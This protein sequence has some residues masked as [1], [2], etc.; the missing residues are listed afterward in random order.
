M[1]LGGQES[2]ERRQEIESRRIWPSVAK[3]YLRAEI[4][5]MWL[6]AGEARGIRGCELPLIGKQ[7]TTSRKGRKQNTKQASSITH[8][9]TQLKSS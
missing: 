8:G 5:R 1:A 9:R 4:G 2:R 6:G 7:L 3:L